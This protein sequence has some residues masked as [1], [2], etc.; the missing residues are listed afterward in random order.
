MRRAKPVLTLVTCYP[1][2]FV[3]DAPQQ[4]LHRAGAVRRFSPPAS[5]P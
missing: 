5:G 4:P 3:V 1:F 2:Y